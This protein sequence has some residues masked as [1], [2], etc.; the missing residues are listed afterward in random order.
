MTKT[1]YRVLFIH[2]NIGSNP[3]GVRDT[4][5]HTNQ[6]GNPSQTAEPPVLLDLPENRS[7]VL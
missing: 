4:V 2:L 6:P 5:S 7:T 1:L 3:A